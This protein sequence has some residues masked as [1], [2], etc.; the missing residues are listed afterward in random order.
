MNSKLLL[1]TL[2]VIAILLLLVIMGMNNADEVSLKMPPLFSKAKK[3][4]AAFMYFGF[5]A[6][7]VLSGTILTAGRKGGSSKSKGE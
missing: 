3:L 6:I 5:F 7:G 2:F 1:K 4:P